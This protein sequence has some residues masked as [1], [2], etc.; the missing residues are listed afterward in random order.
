[1]EGRGPAQHHACFE[2]VVVA[3]IEL[4]PCL[5]VTFESKMLQKVW[6]IR[7]PDMP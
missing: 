1:M 3:H 4:T 2:M 5:T 7:L 6:L